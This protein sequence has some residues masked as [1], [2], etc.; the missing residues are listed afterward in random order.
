MPDSLSASGITIASGETF[1]SIDLSSVHRSS[2]PISERLSVLQWMSMWHMSSTISPQQTR[3]ELYRL[4][5]MDTA[6][7]IKRKRSRMKPII[8]P[9]GEKIIDHLLSSREVR[10]L[11]FGSPGSGKTAILNALCGTKEALLTTKTRYPETSATFS[12]MMRQAKRSGNLGKE[13]AMEKFVVHFIFTEVPEAQAEEQAQRKKNLTE[14]LSMRQC[15]L[16]ML[17]FDV[18]NSA[19]LAYVKHMETTLLDDDMPRTYIATKADQMQPTDAAA[20]QQQHMGDSSDKQSMTVV[21]EAAV[22]CQQTELEAPYVTSAA[23]N[24]T[25]RDQILEHLA[26]C[27]LEEP[28]VDRKQA[29]PYEEKK[30]KEASSRRR[31]RKMIWLGVGVGVAVAMVGYLWTNRSATTTKSGSSDRKSADRFGWL[32]NWF[33]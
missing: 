24:D 20:K 32:R 27:C 10:V 17:T 18:T 11:V 30:R 28:G 7:H 2:F 22:H 21:D 1:P 25:N 29:K 8:T 3:T 19:S 16:V 6:K 23:A 9:S 15:D 4:G 13:V 33:V 26:Q 14:I 31:T 5:H 12:T